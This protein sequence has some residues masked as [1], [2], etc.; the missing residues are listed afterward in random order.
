MP[1]TATPSRR[2]E[3]EASV[4]RRRTLLLSIGILLLVSVV[5]AAV[6]IV[7]GTGGSSRPAKEPV[8]QVRISGQSM[9][10]GDPGADTKVEV[11]EDFGSQGSRAFDLASRDFLRIVAAQ[12]KVLVTYRPTRAT[13]DY[14]QE[15]M[16]AWAAATD[17]GDPARALALHDRLFDRQPGGTAPATDPLPVVTVDGGRLT[18]TD[19]TELAD[20]LQR[21]LLQD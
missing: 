20:R 16:R 6:V 7:G 15:A 14:G 3:D 2:S 17:T 12:G 1:A 21:R 13:G 5:I 11:R 8:A 10:V 9:L 19:G 18:A 4:E